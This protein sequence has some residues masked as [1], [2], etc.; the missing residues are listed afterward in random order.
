MSKEFISMKPETSERYTTNFFTST[1]KAYNFFVLPYITSVLITNPNACVEVCI[2]E[3]DS[4]LETNQEAF[5]VLEILFGNERFCLRSGNFENILP[6]TVRFLETP[7]VKKEYT[8][9]GDVDI[10]VLEEITH[11]HE[12]NMDRIGLPYSNVLRPSKN[13]LTGLH[14]T[15]TDFHYPL[16]EEIIENLDVNL[17]VTNDEV[18]LYKII[19]AK[20]GQFP[21]EENDF[22][23]LHGYHF[24]VNR[25]PLARSGPNWE[26]RNKT[27]L[28]KFKSLEASWEWQRAFPFFD[29]RYKYLYSLAKLTLNYLFPD[30][31]DL[32]SGFIK[33]IVADYQVL[34]LSKGTTSICS[35][36]NTE[37]QLPEEVFSKI[38][39]DNSWKSIESISG[40]G[41]TLAATLKLR[42]GLEE[43]LKKF[44]IK[45]LLDVPCGD[46]HWMKT[47]NMETISIYLGIDIVEELI[48]NNSRQYQN[49]KY[50]FRK[51]NLI[52][53][54]MPSVDL[55]FCRDCLVHFPYQEV[56]QAISRII[57]SGSK[58]LLTTTFLNWKNKDI[59]MGGWRP[60][61]LCEEPFNF[62]EPIE[63]IEERERD[64]LSDPFNDKVMGLWLISDL[65]PILDSYS[66][67]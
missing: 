56:F 6:N 17:Q 32:S 42:E 31:Y 46:F 5:R 13:A 53:D 52:T 12:E 65:Y 63:V 21:Q 9:I 2:E 54:C 39:V 41:S 51:G 14:F 28:T 27:H 20:G 44:Q 19:A 34:P 40:P 50:F 35:S 3:L 16:S 11:Q 60:I 8:Y 67:K 59:K 38:Y 58:Y 1:N 25:S 26:L 49:G 64:N 10:L 48:L 37:G 7:L 4:F 18:V 22:R 23:P 66:L 15:K 57:E 43:L 55:L 29:F 33:K 30:D 36:K 45:T 47:V 62:P 24:S 61:N